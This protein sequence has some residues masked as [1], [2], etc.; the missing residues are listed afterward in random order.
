MTKANFR[1]P[2]V[3]IIPPREKFRP[4]DAGA[5][6]LTVRD[7]FLASKWRRNSIVF[8]GSH[9]GFEGVRYEAVPMSRVKIF[10]LTYSY[11]SSCI[12]RI[13]LIKPS[14]VEV[15]NRINIALSIKK[16]FPNLRVIFYCHN[17]PLGMS[18]LSTPEERRLAV[19]S[20]DGFF[21]VSNFVRNRL[22]DGIDS[23]NIN[24]VH[25]VYNPVE[26]SPGTDVAMRQKRI[27]FAGRVVE[28]KGVRELAIALAQVLPANP[29]WRAVF[30]GASGFGRIA[31]STDYERNVYS[32]LEGCRDQVEFRGHVSH[33]EVIEVFKDARITVAPSVGV[34]AAGRSPLEAMSRG[35]A[36]VLSRSGG[37]VE[38]AGEAAILVDPTTPEAIA[39]ALLPLMHDEMLLRQV[40]AR[41]IEHV[42]QAFALDV[43]VKR[44]DTLRE[45]IGADPANLDGELL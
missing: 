43:I 25:V 23:A 13:R 1:G 22:I 12:D 11:I 21:C 39:S 3:I 36:A 5:I 29:N 41:C 33:R 40:S 32:I 14:V 15:H 8:G 6:A 4:A 20:L 26:I 28:L 31:G 19:A 34:E 35:C 42:R 7:F 9:G 38:I 18:F 45:A 16:A 30:L 44:L 17:D 24:K 2:L 27:V 10:G 37:M